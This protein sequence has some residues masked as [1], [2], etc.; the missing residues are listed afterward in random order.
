MRWRLGVSPT[1]LARCSGPTIETFVMPGV[2]DV[3]GEQIVDA[4]RVALA[5]DRDAERLRP[6]R[7]LAASRCAGRRGRASPRARR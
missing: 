6:G 5:D 1:P 2:G 4:L 7:D 3:H